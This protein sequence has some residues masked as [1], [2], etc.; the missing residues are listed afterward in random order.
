MD[1]MVET[2]PAGS[3]LRLAEHLPTV[4]LAS[5]SSAKCPTTRTRSRVPLLFNRWPCQP[6]RGHCYHSV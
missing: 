2:C 1:R 4:L 3:S 6:A 5:S